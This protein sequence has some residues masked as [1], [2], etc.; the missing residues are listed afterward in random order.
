MPAACVVSGQCICLRR[1]LC[2]DLV[3][4][5]CQQLTRG[6]P[7]AGSL[8]SSTVGPGMAYTLCCWR[9]EARHA[10]GLCRL[11]AAP[12]VHGVMEAV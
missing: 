12:G 4:T 7:G 1:I 10:A 6:H 9:Q 8:H 3:H 11:Q 2:T 5:W